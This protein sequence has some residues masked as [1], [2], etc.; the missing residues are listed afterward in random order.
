MCSYTDIQKFP[1]I[2]AHTR[3]SHE[4][5]YPEKYRTERESKTKAHGSKKKVLSKK[6]IYT[7]PTDIIVAC[8]SNMTR[9]VFD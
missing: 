3:A 1:R 4:N 2:C 9:R 5:R 7:L 6:N 8:Q